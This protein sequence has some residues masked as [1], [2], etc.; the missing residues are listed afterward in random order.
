MSF[1][2]HFS[3]VIIIEQAS[4]GVEGDVGYTCETA[5]YFFLYQVAPL[6]E[7]YYGQV[8]VMGDQVGVVM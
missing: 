8:K 4:I 7:K 6:W 5:S 2:S 3:H 1:M